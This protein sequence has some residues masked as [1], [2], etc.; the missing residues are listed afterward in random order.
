MHTYLKD[1]RTLIFCRNFLV[2][3]PFEDPHVAFQLG[4]EYQRPQPVTLQ[5]VLLLT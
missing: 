3:V 4:D 2:F 1:F 5:N